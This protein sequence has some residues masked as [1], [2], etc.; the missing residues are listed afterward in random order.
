MRVGHNPQRT[1]TLDKQDYLHKIIIP[2]YIPDTTDEYHQFSFQVLQLCINSLLS[3]IH[4][5]TTITIIDNASKKEVAD[6]LNSLLS[7][8]K[9]QQLVRYSCNQGKVDPVIAAMR[10]SLETLITVSDADVLF[11][12]GWQQNVEEVFLQMPHVGMVSPVAQPSQLRYY[13]VWSW[14]FGFKKNCFVNEEN[15]DKESLAKLKHSLG[16]SEAFSEIENYPL[17]IKYNGV[18][19]IIGSGHFCATYHKAVLKYIP[20]KSSG[21]Q[22]LNAEEL[23]MDKP[24][25]EAGL[26][27]LATNLGW[28][29]HIG[30]VPEEWMND[31]INE[32]LNDTTELNFNPS[33]NSIEA[34]SITT[35]KLVNKALIQKMIK[36][37]RFKKLVFKMAKK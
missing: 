32:N 23:F 36:S 30:N 12:K 25:E 22:F 4:S 8:N 2:V 33:I 1:K 11:K 31:I 15:E 19:A 9:I 29:Y 24:V 14:Y 26:M 16:Q 7:Q 17:G 35:G 5:R 10:G 37:P 34:K 13:N 27:R 6:Y 18:K 3:S 21:N 20:Q 28:V